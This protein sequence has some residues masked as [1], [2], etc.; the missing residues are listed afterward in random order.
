MGLFFDTWRSIQYGEESLT[1]TWLGPGFS[2]AL[3][4]FYTLTT[5]LSQ[6]N[7][8]YQTGDSEELQK[9]GLSILKNNAPVLGPILRGPKARSVRRRRRSEGRPSR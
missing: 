3:S 2:Q 4:G 1:N 5:G 7:E 8:A 6:L 9:T